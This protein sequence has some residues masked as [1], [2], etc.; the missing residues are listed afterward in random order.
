MWFGRLCSQD[1]CIAVVKLGQLCFLTNCYFGTHKHTHKC[2]VGIFIVIE[3]QIIFICSWLHSY[4]GLPKVS[5]RNIGLSEFWFPLSTSL[6]FTDMKVVSVY[7]LQQVTD[8]SLLATHEN[9]RGLHQSSQLLVYNKLCIY[10]NYY[11]CVFVIHF[12]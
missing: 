3:F 1:T 11:L 12:H 2:N 10:I 9:Y 8:S 5:P 4:L 6:G 7:Y